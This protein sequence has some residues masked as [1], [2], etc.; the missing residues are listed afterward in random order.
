IFSSIYADLTLN[1]DKFFKQ[2]RQAASD[3]GLTISSRC[4]LVVPKKE[5]KE[6]SDVEKR[7]SG[8]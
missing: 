4:K 2:C 5:E 1:Q 3:L 7:F 6:P 8:V